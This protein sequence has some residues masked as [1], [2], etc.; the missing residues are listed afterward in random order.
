MAILLNL[1]KP[2]QGIHGVYSINRAGSLAAADAV[3]GHN[4]LRVF[5]DQDHNRFSI[6]LGSF[7]FPVMDTAR[8]QQS[9]VNEIAQVLKWQ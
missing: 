1:V 3:S 6:S 2:R 8:R 7:I 5:V 9:E 4:I